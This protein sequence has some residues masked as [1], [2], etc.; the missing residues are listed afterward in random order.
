MTRRRPAALPSI[1]ER[2]CRCWEDEAGFVEAIQTMTIEAPRP[3]RPR[4]LLSAY[5]CDPEQGSEPG[6]GWNRAVQA[7]R[8][9]DTWVLCEEGRYGAA[10]RRYLADHGPI[11]G[12]E[13]VYVPRTAM[14]QWLGKLPGMRYVAYNGWQRSALRA[15][16]ALHAR[17]GFDLTHQVTFCGYREPGYLWKLGVPFVWGPIGGTQNYPWRFLAESGCSGAFRE[18]GRNVLNAVQMRFSPLVRRAVHAAAVVLAANTSIQ[19]DLARVH[20]IDAEVQLE[21]GLRAVAARPRPLPPEG[22]PLR[23]LWS[24]EVQPWKA[25]TLLLR[26]L[27]RIPASVPVE[28]RILGHGPLE[29]AARRLAGRLGVANR[30]SWLGWLPFREA[31]AQYDWADVFVFTSLRDTSGNV[32]LESLAA[33]VPVVCLDHQGVHDMVTPECGIRIPVTTPD[34]VIGRLAEALTTLGADREGRA[35]L[36]G[37]ALER[38]RCY[39]WDVQGERMLKVYR[40][41]LGDGF[42]WESR[43]PPVDQTL[44]GAGR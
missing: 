32:V 25:L 21:T 40:E 2:L 16:R 23:V 18:G 31:L 12:L 10:V 20:A 13:F 7:A 1:A 30:L 26:A 39:L 9:C 38:A 5:A 17:I 29:A 36:G 42:C 35:R 15:A 34:E 14:Q 44:C 8:Y 37:G 24:G 43:R 41:V 3:R 19:A 27:A 4:L 6:V 28:V 11:P 33:G 22:T